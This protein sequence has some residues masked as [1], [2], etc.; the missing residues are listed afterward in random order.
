[1]S[2][3]IEEQCR[4]AALQREKLR[5]LDSVESQVDPLGR[6]RVEGPLCLARQSLKG[7]PYAWSEG[8][9][10]VL[11]IDDMRIGQ[12]HRVVCPHQWRRYG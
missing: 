5:R 8:P 4:A 7:N 12:G 11:N 3:M 6:A 1:M 9:Y 2:S 10:K